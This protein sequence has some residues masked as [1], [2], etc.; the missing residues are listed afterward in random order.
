MSSGDD[1]TKSCSAMSEGDPTKSSSDGG[2]GW[3][4]SSATAGRGRAAAMG[5]SSMTS[6]AKD[7]GRAAIRGSTL[8][9]DGMRY[10]R[11]GRR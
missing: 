1:E 2:E 11:L 8:P 6:L 5:E 3:S 4:A 7:S 9:N 10:D